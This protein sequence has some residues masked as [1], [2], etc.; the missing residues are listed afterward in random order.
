MP[1]NGTSL[2]RDAIRSAIARVLDSARSGRGSTL[3]IVGGPG[4]GKTVALSE[5]E[6]LAGPG[7]RVARAAGDP[8]EVALPYGL[9]A[10]AVDYLGARELLQGARVVLGEGARSAPF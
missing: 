7:A 2:E 3:F 4:L 6:E 10:Q 5:L 8:M 1:N 9:I